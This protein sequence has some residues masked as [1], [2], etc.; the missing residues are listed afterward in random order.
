MKKKVIL[1]LI[2]TVLVLMGM[3]I[4]FEY[5]VSRPCPEAVMVPIGLIIFV[6]LIWY[7]IYT[8]KLGIKIFKN[9]K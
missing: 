3:D 8:I 9:K 4:Y 5:C 2:A 1:W 7:L 6:G